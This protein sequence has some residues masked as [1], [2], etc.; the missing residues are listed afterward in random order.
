[1]SAAAAAAAT[2]RGRSAIEALMVDACTITR[3]TDTTTDLQTAAVTATADT[4]YSG[5]CRIQ[6]QGHIA[7][8]VT[9]GGSYEFQSAFELQVPMSAIGILVNDI[10]TVTA[11]VLDQDL[12]GRSYWVKEPAAKTHATSRRF[13]IELVSG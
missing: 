9:V 2:L 10:V 11:S 13:G 8:P 4:I 12:V 7:R 1:M 6:Q 3:V 5:K